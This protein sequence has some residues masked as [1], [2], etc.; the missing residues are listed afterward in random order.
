MI[1]FFFT[2]STVNICTYERTY[3]GECLHQA[4]IAH[5]KCLLFGALIFILESLLFYAHFHISLWFGVSSVILK[6]TT[7]WELRLIR[8]ENPMNHRDEKNTHTKFERKKTYI[9]VFTS[10]KHAPAYFHLILFVS[11]CVKAN[12]QKMPC[13]R[14]T[15]TI[16][17]RQFL[18]ASV[19]FLCHRLLLCVRLF[20]NLPSLLT[21]CIDFLR[22]YFVRILS[23]AKNSMKNESTPVVEYQKCPN[24]YA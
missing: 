14:L 10:N 4:F 8:M 21:D 24:M 20:A 11:S 17:R 15:S 12:K 1:L 7:N 19:L 2:L 5:F 18:F 22:I 16:Y 23:L 9:H 3:R 13:S 6:S